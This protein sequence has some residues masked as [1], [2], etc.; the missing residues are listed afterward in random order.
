MT[1]KTNLLVTKA[2]RLAAP[3]GALATLAL[4]LTYFFGHNGLLGLG[5]D[6][7]SAG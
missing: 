5:D 3:A 1:T 2:K 6:G 7:F 4:T